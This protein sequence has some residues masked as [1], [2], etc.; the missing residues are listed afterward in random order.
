MRIVHNTP[1]RII[2]DLTFVDLGSN[3]RRGKGRSNFEIKGRD[4]GKVEIINT[5]VYWVA[6]DTSG[7]N[8]HKLYHYEEQ[9]HMKGAKKKKSGNKKIQTR[10]KDN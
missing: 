1:L 6:T 3:W 8:N 10:C 9:I 7:T 5:G 4:E 2:T